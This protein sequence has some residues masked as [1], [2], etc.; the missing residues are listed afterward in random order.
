MEEEG[1][2][3]VR[4]FTLKAI[5]VGVLGCLA[6]VAAD[7]ILGPLTGFVATAEVSVMTVVI[8][9]LIQMFL[10]FRASYAEYA[11]I[12]AMV[13]GA[14]ASYT[15]WRTYAT[16][17]MQYAT[18]YPWLTEE[19]KK[20]IPSYFKIL[21]K[22]FFDMA[23]EGGHPAP[24]GQLMGVTILGTVIT[25]FFGLLGMF[26]LAPFRRQIV[27]V[28]RLPY[29]ATTA[30]FTAVSLAM[31]PPP[32]EERA[33][34]L[35][36]R[37]NWLL[38]GLIIGIILTL[39]GP[40]Y[41]ISEAFPGAPTIPEAVGDRA[42]DPGSLWHI[43][44][45]AAIGLDM[46]AF[47][48][49]SFF[50]YFW[51]MDALLTVTL[52]T[53]LVNFLVV[54]YMVQA[55][56]IEFDPTMPV[57]DLYFSAWYTG[58]YKLHV[59]GSALLI[60]GVLGGYIAA[61]RYIL[62]SFKEKEREPGFISPQ[63][64]WILAIVAVVALTA[65]MV[66]LGAPVGPALLSSLFL[67]F[68]YQM[69]GIRGLGICNLQ[70]TWV[71]HAFAPVGYISTYTGMLYTGELSP[72]LAGFVVGTCHYADYGDI[73]PS[74]FFESSRFAFLGRVKNIGTIVVAIVIGLVIGG[75]FGS[76][77]EQHLGFGF[78]VTHRLARD[79][80]YV[81]YSPGIRP[82]YLLRFYRYGFTFY[83][84]KDAALALYCAL[85]GIGALL[86]ILA[87]RIVMPFN[88]IAAGLAILE[89]IGANLDWGYQALVYLV[90]K[91]LILRIGGTKLDEQVARPF[92]AGAAAGG[93]LGA[94]ISGVYVAYKAFYGV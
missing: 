3:P 4:A 19:Y 6:L 56:L 22:E 15:G 47:F 90:I 12:Y 26:A 57:G 37:R 24:F 46:H 81:L 25:M 5:V 28:E 88:S 54:P 13:Y 49:W 41:L 92:F 43:L 20:F 42:G 55:K 64:Q 87:T 44:P 60:G 38:L 67:L 48:P 40:G 82:H 45:G 91:W 69:W 75:I 94:V 10:R 17:L 29:P 78:G 61:W 34:V 72:A 66:S 83:G 33:P 86:P 59:L 77:Y 84:V 89:C 53:L 85:I 16:C 52:V 18:G 93:L 31:E 80:A 76:I 30:A 74:A 35:G 68:I 39:F 58:D 7:V 50:C 70:F 65:F 1:E 71:A 32:K 79:A 62:Q 27:E 73:V 51:P 14:A 9:A 2:V 63:L 11:V 36:S 8:V 23:M 21:P